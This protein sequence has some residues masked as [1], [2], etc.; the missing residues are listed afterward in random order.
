MTGDDTQTQ[1]VIESGALPPLGALLQHSKTQLQKEA[2]WAIS[3]VAAGTVQQISM[4]I[5]HGTLFSPSF[6]AP[7]VPNHAN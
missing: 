2:T 1:H 5:E 3:N 4:L 7:R 6:E